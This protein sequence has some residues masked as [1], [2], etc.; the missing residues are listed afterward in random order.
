ML[1]NK[2]ELNYNYD[3]LGV[4]PSIIY[5]LINNNNQFCKKLSEMNKPIMII[6]QGALK[7]D[8]REDYLNLCIE[9]A[10]N[11]NFLKIIGMVLMFFIQRHQDLGQ[12]KLVF[13]LGR[14]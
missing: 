8:E 2:S 6:G 5:D 12:W 1:G 10:N 9:L 7:G 13:Y 4:D 14:R 11:Y 3:Y